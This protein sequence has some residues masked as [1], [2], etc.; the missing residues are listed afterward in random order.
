MTG[1]PCVGPRGITELSRRLNSPL[2]LLLLSPIPTLPCSALQ[3]KRRPSFL[4][5]RT[6]PFEDLSNVVV[7]LPPREW[8]HGDK[9]RRIDHLYEPHA[10]E[11]LHKKVTLLVSSC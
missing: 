11:R 6:E 1:M 8:P 7:D 10:L 5:K 2:C 4:H 9:G 3:Q